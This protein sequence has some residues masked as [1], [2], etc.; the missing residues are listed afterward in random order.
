V[1]QNLLGHQY[2]RS[3][4]QV[5]RRTILGVSD[6]GLSPYPS[7][8]RGF[9]AVQQGCLEGFQETPV[10]SCKRHILAQS[11]AHAHPEV[12]QLCQ[13]TPL[14]IAQIEATRAFPEAAVGLK[15]GTTGQIP[16]LTGPQCF[17]TQS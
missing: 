8:A 14:H 17:S 12:A 10:R 3:L 13:A 11:D 7:T 16:F 4:I 6:E 1:V 9:V 2:L 5:R 15:N